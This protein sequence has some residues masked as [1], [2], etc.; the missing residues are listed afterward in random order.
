[1]R[2]MR[3]ALYEGAAA[4]ADLLARAAGRS[5][6]A[7]ERRAAAAGW[8]LAAA[9]R[10]GRM[11]RVVDGLIA[12]VEAIAKDAEGGQGRLDKARIESVLAMART[13]E[14]LGEMARVDDAA[15]ENQSSAD[16]EDLASILRRIDERIVELAHGYARELAG[17]EP[18]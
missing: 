2:G 17:K 8:T 4:S 1:M 12:E 14:K 5:V 3:C 13:L 11:A 6:G 18:E 9:D 10:D 7:I 16:D 15:K